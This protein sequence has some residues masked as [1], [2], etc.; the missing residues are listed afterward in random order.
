MHLTKCTIYDHYRT[1]GGH[2]ATY[3]LV[4]TK[5]KKLWLEVHVH[6]LAKSMQD[7]VGMSCVHNATNKMG[8]LCLA[9]SMANSLYT[10]LLTRFNKRITKIFPTLSL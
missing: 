10:Q 4:H 2:T 5:R 6:I 7:N 8:S 9:R 1:K 3:I